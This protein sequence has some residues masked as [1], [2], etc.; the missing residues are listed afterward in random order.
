MIFLTRRARME[1]NFQASTA[2]ICALDRGAQRRASAARAS[3]ACSSRA[4]RPRGV[5]RARRRRYARVEVAREGVELDEV[6][7]LAR[8]RGCSCTC[9]RARG[10]AQ[11]TAPD[12]AAGLRAARARR[13]A[14]GA[15]A[16]RG[17][18]AWGSSARR[19]GFPSCS[20]TRR[21]R[22]AASSTERSSRAVHPDNVPL[23]AVL[24]QRARARAPPVAPPAAVRQDR[25]AP[26]RRRSPPILQTPQALTSEYASSP[27]G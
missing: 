20:R 12:P 16:E 7:R 15:A 23:V 14:A 13:S 26:A 2:Q 4:R 19:S 18:P 17:R 8:G 9:H 27:M 5:R 3:T 11:R 1:R 22:A 6:D 10:R 24:A 21:V 25:R